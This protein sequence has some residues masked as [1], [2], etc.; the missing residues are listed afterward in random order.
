MTASDPSPLPIAMSG[1]SGPSTTPN[2]SVASAA[3]KTPGSSIG[4]SAPPVFSPSA[5][6]C[7]PGPGRWRMASAVSRPPMAT[8]G[9]GH[10]TGA[11]SKPNHPGASSNTTCC[12]LVDSSRKP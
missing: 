12:S 9:T 2:V 11:V 1:A 10:H 8:R 4:G 6:E 5:G 7:P 3:K